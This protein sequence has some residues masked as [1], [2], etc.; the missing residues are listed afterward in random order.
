[1]KGNANTL[2]SIA[3]AAGRTTLESLVLAE[4]GG[5]SEKEL[6]KVASDGKTASCA[7]LWLARA[8]NFILKMLTVMIAERGKKLSECVMAGYEV[9]LRPHHGM[10]IR[11]TFSMAVKAAPDRAEFIAKLREE[12]FTPREVSDRQADAIFKLADEGDEFDDGRVG[13]IKWDRAKEIFRSMHEVVDR[14]LIW[15]TLDQYAD[16]PVPATPR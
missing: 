3:A 10:M 4:C 1:M 15:Q 6:K 9:S 16:P 14:R 2:K 7:L 13:F 8:L 5:K 12:G 11:S